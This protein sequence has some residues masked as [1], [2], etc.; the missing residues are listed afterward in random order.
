MVSG[1][2]NSLACSAASSSLVA[3]P[4]LIA[5]D[6]D[7][8][9]SAVCHGWPAAVSPRR[10]FAR[11]AASA[12]SVAAN[13]AFRLLCADADSLSVRS[14]MVVLALDA[15]GVGEACPRAIVPCPQDYR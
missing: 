3:S 13:D 11:L 2:L 4:L 15:R 8:S 1:S 14:R 9:S 5:S 7:G 6:A 10:A 12:A